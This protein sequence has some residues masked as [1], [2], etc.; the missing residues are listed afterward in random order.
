MNV[1]DIT[2][3]IA[4]RSANWIAG[5][6]PISLLADDAKRRLLGAVK[7]AGYQPPAPRANALAATT[8]LPSSID[9]RNNNG[10]FVTSVKD[11]GGC[12]SCVAFGTMAAM[13]TRFAIEQSM[14]LDFSEADMFFCSSHGAVCT[15]WWPQPAY[16]ANQQRGIIQECLFPY[17]SA[18]PNNNTGTMPPHCDVIANRADNAFLYSAINTVTGV[19]DAK[20]YLVT[21]GPLAACFDVYEDFFHYTS[22]V[23]THTTGT[24]VGGHCICIVGYVDTDNQGN[25]Y[26]ICK[27]SWGPGWGMAG[28]FNIAYGQCNIDTYEKVGVSGITQPINTYVT[29]G[30][31]AFPNV[32]LRMD[33]NG[34]TQPVGTGG[35]TVNC[36][37][38]AGPWEKFVLTRQASGAYTVG[39]MAFPN[40]FLRMD[41]NGVIQP[42]GPGGGTVNCQYT[43]GPWEQYA[44]IRQPGGTYTFESKNF[45]NVFLRLDGSGVTQPVGPGGGTVNCQYTAGPWEQF[46]LAD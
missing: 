4:N 12:G 24:Y 23:Y 37:Y 29:L 5:N 46:I 7:P 18:F 10:N 40:V 28:Y 9:W 32:F 19:A 21:T 17:P 41:G 34:V 1:Q 11:Q 20:N 36:Q 16:Q 42:V 13:E 26:W 6:N 35:G 45:P 30:S 25:G 31:K 14:L 2:A 8:A 3:A 38:T 33:G 15:G 27:N 22:G 44:V 39:S 43:A